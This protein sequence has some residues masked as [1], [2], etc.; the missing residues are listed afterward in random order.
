M[1]REAVH[2]EAQIERRGWAYIK[3]QLGAFLALLKFR[4]SFIV[5]LS[6]SFGYAMGGEGSATVWNI[7]LMGLGG[8]LITGS[9]NTFNQILERDTDKLMGR[10]AGRPLPMGKLG[11]SSALT[12]AILTGIAGVVLVG[13]LFN[14]VAA[15]LGIIGLLSY[16]FVYTPLKKHTPFAVFVGAIP[17]AL[18]PLIGWTAFTGEIGSGGIIIFLFQFMWQFPHFWAIAWLLEEDYKKAGFNLLPTV[19]GKTNN[20]AR[21]IFIYTMSLIPLALFPLL[22]GML[23]W[24]GMV[25]LMLCGMAF[26][27]PAFK[28]YRTMEQASAKKLLLASFLYLPAIQLI[29]L[30]M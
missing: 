11:L 30:F 27:Y 24:P 7:F 17:G 20:N 23:E 22:S 2:T 25:A 13:Y 5:A 29:F 26:C 28:L 8:L 21:L 15:L 19:E 6:A 3:E 4:L 9:A 1:I 16:A 10:T 14:L 12:F 18:P